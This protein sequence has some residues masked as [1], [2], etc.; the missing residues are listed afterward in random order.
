MCL[1]MWWT[2]CLLNEHRRTFGLLR[3]R[4]SKLIADRTC[5]RLFYLAMA[6][7]GGASTVLRVPIDR[8]IRSLSIETA[9]VGFEM[10][11]KIV[12]LH[13]ACV[14]TESVSQTA[15]PGASRSQFSR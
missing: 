12:A 15:L 3:S 7:N 1:G 14:S 9:T 13:V 11:D 6:W 4:Y 5:R 2:R 8:V 10:P